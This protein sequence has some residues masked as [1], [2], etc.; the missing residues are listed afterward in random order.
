MLTQNSLGL[1]SPSWAKSGCLFLTTFWRPFLRYDSYLVSHKQSISQVKSKC[2]GI[3]R[4][5]SK[6]L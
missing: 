3:R 5:L 4:M 6:N 1:C 2:G